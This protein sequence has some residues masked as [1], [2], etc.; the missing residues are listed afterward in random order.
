[1]P[2][3]QTNRPLSVYSTQ[4]WALMRLTVIWLNILQSP[5]VRRAAGPRLSAPVGAAEE[6]GS[7]L[8]SFQMTSPCPCR[9]G[10]MKCHRVGCASLKMSEKQ[11]LVVRG[12]A[13]GRWQIKGESGTILLK[14]TKTSLQRV[15]FRWCWH[16]WLSKGTF[17]Q[18]IRF[19]IK[20]LQLAQHILFSSQKCKCQ[21]CF[22]ISASSRVMF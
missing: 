1:M 22:V 5:S 6:A 4:G 3:T 8:P 19:G 16:F 11:Q 17:W 20:T 21:S 13:R 15:F 2:W 18:E 10:N 7:L 12:S 9:G 14:I